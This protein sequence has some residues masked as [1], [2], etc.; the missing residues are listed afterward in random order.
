MHAYLYVVY[1]YASV[2]CTAWS[3]IGYEWVFLG[4][5][6]CVHSIQCSTCALGLY[7]NVSLTEVDMALHDMGFML[8]E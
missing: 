6:F 4:M 5:M 2:K 8:T 7:S 1:V 3:G